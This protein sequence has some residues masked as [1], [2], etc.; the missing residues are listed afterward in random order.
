MADA[1]TI[2]D[3][4]RVEAENFMEQY[5]V[6]KL[7][8][9][10]D[11]SKGSAVRDLVIGAMAYIFAYLKK[12]R[13]Y[14]RARQSLLL[15]GT[16]TG[17]DADDA[18]DEI[19]SNWFLTRKTGRKATGRVTVYLSKSIDVSIPATTMFYKT[20]TAVFY[21]NSKSTLT[22]GPDDLL[23]IRNSNGEISAYSFD[24]PVIAADTGVD[25]NVDPGPFSDFT[26]FS[27]YI[28]RVENQNAISTGTEIE[29]TVDLLDRAP[30]A[31]T[32]RDLNSSRS[33]DATLRD[34]FEIDQVSVIGYG[35][36][37]MI[38]DLIAEEATGT[39]I[40]AGGC[41]DVFL[42]QPITESK[43]F[44]GVVGGEFTDPRPF[45]TSFRDDTVPDFSGVQA[46]DILKIYNNLSVSE[47]NLY[48]VKSSSKYGAEVSPRSSFPGELPEV[49]LSGADGV[50][51]VSTHQ[52]SSASH[53]FITVSLALTDD[54][55]VGAGGSSVRSNAYV[56]TTD[57]VD[58]WIQITGSTEGN[59]GI[60]RI[61]AINTTPSLSAELRSATGV[62]PSFSVETG[63][64]WNLLLSTDHDKYIWTRETASPVN[65]GVWNIYEILDAH[66]VSLVAADGSFPSFTSETAISWKLCTR[67][68]EYSLGNNSPSYSNLVSKRYSGQ[69][70]NT[71]QFDGRILMPAEPIYRV[72]DVS[73]VDDTN[74]YAQADGRVYFSVRSNKEPEY[75]E[76][77]EPNKLILE[78]RVIC[79]N[80][81]EAQSGWQRM[82]L[83]IGWPDGADLPYEKKNYFNGKSLRITY[84][85]ITG[86]DTI[87][88]Y[89]LSGD[90]RILCGSVIPRGFHPVYLTLSIRYR[91]AKNATE[92]LDEDAAK[93]ALANYVIDSSADDPIDLSDLMYFLR[94]TYPVIG[95]VEPFDIYYILIAPDGRLIYYKTSDA[96]S[97]SSSLIIDPETGF[98]P[99]P[100]EKPE[101]L[102]QDPLGL[103]V[104]TN[105]VRY[106]SSPELITF[107]QLS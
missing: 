62:P 82:I 89:M 44:T 9:K 107:T 84:D 67:V 54:A 78:Y 17:T 57:D 64:D 20:S 36:S 80:P 68:V 52:F 106:L 97:L 94:S 18:V 99:N 58:K 47:A 5:L 40:H 34:N 85:T 75:L 86:Y 12:E 79:D 81:S 23:P 76:P 7:K 42:R 88:A 10:A 38:R 28:L 29:S 91:L 25:Y 49:E 6:D 35:D 4:D 27:A 63:L 26:R 14:I 13:D 92:G 45:R 104:S 3:A 93:Q 16:L 50:T 65:T 66:T 72:K 39:R 95:Y 21:P 60:W 74:P 105:T 101:L 102:L 22:Y 1:I 41:V 15:L 51:T 31:I 100:S 53:E 98:I 2:T 96:I 8:D 71:V 24:V 61:V 48:V 83:D 43:T 90:Q 33:I 55:F 70:T 32:V 69:F 59:N 56:F 46:G 77:T 103:G 87:W 11:F 73:F 30:T 19:M 37:E